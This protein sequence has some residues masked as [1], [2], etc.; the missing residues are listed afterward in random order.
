MHLL[1]L[2]LLILSVSLMIIVANPINAQLDQKEWIPLPSECPS[3]K[4]SSNEITCERQ[5][6]GTIIILPASYNKD[7]T[8][9]ALIILP[10]T[11]GTPS[12]YFGGDFSA[13]YKARDT[14]EKSFIV[15][16]PNVVGKQ[17]DWDPP[18]N[19][20]SA[21]QRNEEFVKSDLK[22]L[23]PKYNIDSSR[24]VIGGSSLGGDLSCALSVRNPKLFQGVVVI[25][26]QCTAT[27][28]EPN[29][30]NL[31]T[32]NIRFFM[33]M[34]EADDY[35]RLPDMRRAVDELVKYGISNRF[36]IIPSDNGSSRTARL[37]RGI[38]YI[39]FS[40]DFSAR[41]EI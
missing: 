26:S 23:V 9:P 7:K 31:A 8:Y 6:N 12:D 22:I 27:G 5:N 35:D 3:S 38:D 15:F 34:D 18:Q 1:K 19:F 37:M 4:G 17:S 21:I 20:A 32:H 10:F 41:P 40:K 13:K 25:N 30:R 24:L 39:L 29:M 28:D 14:Y 11:G 36:E 33:S 16:L 2:G